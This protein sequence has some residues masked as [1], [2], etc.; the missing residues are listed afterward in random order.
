MFPY[1]GGIYTAYDDDI[2]PSHWCWLLS[3]FKTTTL[4]WRWLSPA[5][6]FFGVDTSL[7]ARLSGARSVILPGFVFKVVSPLFEAFSFSGLVSV[8]MSLYFGFAAAFTLLQK[9]Y[10]GSL[11]SSL[12]YKDEDFINDA[13]I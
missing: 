4:L 9:Y 6:R 13:A 3:W 8:P 1:A 5:S 2:C 12:C 10:T 11:L 7:N